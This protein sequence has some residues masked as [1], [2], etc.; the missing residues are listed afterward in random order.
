MLG[1]WKRT[2][3]RI[4][5]RIV[6]PQCPSDS[7]RSAWGALEGKLKAFSPC[8]LRG[9]SQS[10]IPGAPAPGSTQRALGCVH[11]RHQGGQR[12]PMVKA[13]GL[14]LGCPGRVPMT[15]RTLSA[16]G[17]W[18]ELHCKG[19]QGLGAPERHWAQGP[20]VLWAWPPGCHRGSDCPR[21]SS[22]VSGPGP[23]TGGLHLLQVSWS[24]GCPEACSPSS[25]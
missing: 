12:A 19:P 1:T 10:W 2:R 11:P 23:G 17:G 25:L 5:C 8:H 24:A 16:P 15:P 21:G 13:D 9:W 3:T 14:G 4:S 7:P 6:G 22:T 20:G 18:S